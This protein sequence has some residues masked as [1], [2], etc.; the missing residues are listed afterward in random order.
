M[1]IEKENLCSLWLENEEGEKF[2]PNFKDLG[3]MWDGVPE[4]FIYHHSKFPT[5][6]HHSILRFVVKEEVENCKHPKEYITPTS[7]WI[8]GVEGR[9][10]KLCNGSQTKNIDESWPEKWNANGTRSFMSMES[11]WSEDLVL[12]M[13]TKRKP[14]FLRKSFFDFSKFTLSES[15]IIGANTCEACMNVLRYHYLGKKEGYKEGSE[16]WKIA[17]TSCDFC[18]RHK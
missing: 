15:I 12:A 10:C 6:L 4:G 16:E 8:D 11:G 7:G 17:N 18:N 3:K 5:Q 14:K 9:E 13:A 1:K 2:F